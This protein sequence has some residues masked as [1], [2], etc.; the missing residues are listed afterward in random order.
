MRRLI[1]FIL[2]FLIMVMMELIYTIYKKD[3]LIWTEFLCGSEIPLNLVFNKKK[4]KK[5][6]RTIW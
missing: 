2:E 5:K 1:K 4:T 6:L 3:S